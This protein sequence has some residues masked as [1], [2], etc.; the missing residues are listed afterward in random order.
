M[1]T[2]ANEHEMHM[3]LRGCLQAAYLFTV[4]CIYT[5]YVSNMGISLK[6]TKTSQTTK[7]HDQEDFSGKMYK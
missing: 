7:Q 3:S 5:I 4:F 1:Y 6:E 2:L